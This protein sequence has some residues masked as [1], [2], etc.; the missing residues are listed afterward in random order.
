MK[1]L[2]SDGYQF[3]SKYNVN[4]ALLC[5]VLFRMVELEFV[6][7]VER[8]LAVLTCNEGPIWQDKD[9]K[10]SVGP[11]S[12]IMLHFTELLFCPK[13]PCSVRWLVVLRI[14]VA[15]VIFQPY[16]DLEAGDNQSLKS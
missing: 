5:Y 1:R 9:A 10:V 16:R 6:S 13:K 15:S 3:E 12:E 8:S 14:N 7:L 2:Y 4:N 11:D